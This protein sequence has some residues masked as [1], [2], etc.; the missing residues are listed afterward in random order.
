METDVGLR[1]FGTHE[2]H[3]G[4]VVN[5]EASGGLD[6]D[7]IELSPGLRERADLQPIASVHKCRGDDDVRAVEFRCSHSLYRE[8]RLTSGR[9][10]EVRFKQDD[11]SFRE[12][13][14][15]PQ[16]DVVAKT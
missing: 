2:H 11:R 3:R 4:K 14:P 10:L 9:A 15:S 12:D 16:R 7:S 6:E 5:A 8:R 1:A 13:D